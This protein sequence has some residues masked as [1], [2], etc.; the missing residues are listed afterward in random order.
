LSAKRLESLNNEAH[1]LNLAIRLKTQ[2]E[3]FAIV[4]KAL[5]DLATTSLEERLGEIFTRRLRE[6]DD[7]T[8]QGIGQVLKTA[9]AP[10]VVR[11]AF[12]LPAEQC[13]AIQNALNETF[14]AEI[15][16]RFETAPDII[17]GIELSVNGWKVAWSIDDYLAALEKSVCE[18]VNEQIKPK[19]PEAVK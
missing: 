13:A 18:L 8:R 1:N 15:Q 11:S 19:A 4:R 5:T 9:S 7:Q 3:V 14:S 16:V 2:Q 17:S 12:E 6:L 10:A